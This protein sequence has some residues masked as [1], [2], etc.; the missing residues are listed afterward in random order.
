MRTEEDIRAAY[1]ALARQAPDAGAVLTAVRE[2]LEPASAGLRQD[3]RGRRP[4]AALAS[5]VAVMAVI[6]GSISLAVGGHVPHRAARSQGQAANSRPGPGGAAPRYYVALVVRHASRSL[7]MRAYAV[8]NDTATGATLATAT[9]PKPFRRFVTVAGAADDRTFVLAVDRLQVGSANPPV[10]LFRAQYEPGRRKITLT[11]LPIPAIPGNEQINGLA[12]SPDGSRLAISTTVFDRGRSEKVSVYSMTSGTVKVWRQA[13]VAPA[14]RLSWG[15]G[16]ML[17]YNWDDS[18]RYGVW[19]LNTATAGGGLIAHSR[20]AVAVPQGWAFGYGGLLTADG[21]TVVT[22][23]G[24]MLTHLPPGINYELAEYSAATGRKTRVLLP[25]HDGGPE[26]MWTSPSGT[27]LVVQT[28]ATS[29]PGLV[30]DVLSGS[31]LTPI[32]NPAFASEPI[33]F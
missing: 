17:A 18:P 11:A 33:A 14:Y 9:P 28:S 7:P 22:A 3:R 19:L 31:R 10:N 15:R 2:R 30:L 6:G 27:V 13:S 26:L 23:Q 4:L 25:S 8:V 5:A 21:R 12:L 24:R 32:P 1:R 29:G 20:L 16:G